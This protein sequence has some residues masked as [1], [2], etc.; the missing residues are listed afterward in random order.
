MIRITEIVLPLN[1]QM[2]EE[3]EYLKKQ[4]AKRL[5]ISVGQ[6]ESI[7]LFKKSVDARK[8]DAIVFRCTVD[9]A[10]KQEQTIFTKARDKKSSIVKPYQYEMPVC[11]KLEK[12][13]VVVGFGPAGMFAALLL[14]QAGQCPIVVERGGSV[15]DR[16]QQV[17]SFWNGGTLNTQ[18]NVQ[19]GEG[20]A[21]TFSDG[22]LNTGTKDIRARKVLE[23]LHAA[24]APEEIL[25]LAHP[26]VG[27]DKLPQTVRTIRE[28][29]K[30][31]GGD[32][33][34]STQLT[35]IRTKDGVVTAA[36]VNGLDGEQVLETDHLILAIGH[37]ARDTYE[38]LDRMGLVMQQKPFS[39]G[40]RIEHPQSLIN[41][42]QYG[43]FAEHPALGAA[44]YKLAV[45]LP[46]GRG[47]YTFCMCPGGDVVAAASEEGMVV[48]NGMSNFARDGANANAALLVGIG[49]E[50]FGGEH[51]LAG[52]HLQRM[53]EHAA[54][55]F[56]GSN[57]KA[58]AQRVEDF[59]NKKPSTHFGD[60]HPT[61]QRG[62]EPSDL[63]DLLPN[64]IAESMMEGIR[65]LDH[66]LSG[67][68][69]PD[70]VL[71]GVETRSSAPV[72]LLRNEKLQSVS[73]Q[74]LYPCGEGAG[75]AGGIVS[76]AVDGLKCAEMVLESV[77][78]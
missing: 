58:P 31:L 20:G 53:L 50:D 49:P 11:N 2:A 71:T 60:V 64:F 15:E 73:L 29:I 3:M 46:D 57:Y 34:F 69:Y 4:A 36:V 65:M 38:M 27:T 63:H 59:L 51:P 30:K 1:V 33:L 45:H 68:A 42:A 76:A 22:K 78:K 52:M 12:R 24:G 66:R 39:V 5:K 7:T 56:G 32:V 74:G 70:A 8:K 72:R 14:A 10:V 75:Y 17:E 43:D 37:S 6:I 25:Y 67:F 41:K 23:E 21:G 47:V 55:R 18:C 40:A 62:V 16:Q 9:V 19:F 35:A 61:Y 13:P 77:K 48:T 44:E 26:H 54:F 28:T